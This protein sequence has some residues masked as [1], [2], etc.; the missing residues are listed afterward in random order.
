MPSPKIISLIPVILSLILLLFYRVPVWAQTRTG[1]ISGTIRG[2]DGKA[3]E[4]ATVLL[5]RQKDS[6]ISRTAVSDK[7]GGFIFHGVAT[8]TYFLSVTSI[9]FET[10]RSGPIAA[11]SGSSD[12]VLPDIVLS[13][14]ARNLQAVSVTDK[15]FVEWKL[16]KL[17]VHVAT[18]PFF[19]PGQ[20]TVDVLERSPGINID[21]MSNTISL[22][23]RAGTA[24]YIN[25][26]ISYLSGADLINYLRGLP[27]GSLDQIEIMSQPSAKYD[28]GGSGGAINIVLK[29]NQANGVFGSITTSVILGFYPKTRDNFLLNWRKDKFNLNFSYGFSDYKSFNDQHILSS[30][31]SDYGVAFSQYQDYRNSVI[32]TNLSHTPRLALDYQASKNTSLGL[33]LTGLFSSNKS[34]TNGPINLTD[35]LHSLI[36]KE[37]FS[38]LADNP[39]SN[40]GVNLNLQ[41]KLDGK[42]KELSVDA[43]YLHYHSPGSQSSY[44]YPYDQAGNP[45]APYLLN[46]DFP[47]GVNIYAFK[48][49][50]SQPFH[51]G[52]GKPATTGTGENKL[53]AGFKSS[54]VRTDN[55]AQYTLYDTLQKQWQP[56]TALSNHFIYSENINAAYVN[57]GKQ[58]NKKWSVE[59]GARAEQTL[60]R[61]NETTQG[62]RFTRKYFQVFPTL[63][64]GFSPNEVHSFTL[65]YGR[66]TDRPSY[67][68]L[69]PFRY[70]IN[71]YN[72]RQGNPNLQPE[73]VNNFE[74][75]YHYKSEFVV[76]LDYIK[77]DNLFSRIY[78]SSGTGNDL[79]TILTKE[80]VASRRNIFLFFFYNK[81]LTKWW[82]TN[83]T[84]ATVNSRIADP[85]DKGNPIDQVMVYRFD[86]NNKFSLPKGWGLELRGN[87]AGRRLEG[88]HIYALASGYLSL[89]V[90][91]KVLQGK[92]TLTANLNDALDLYR[93][94]QTS[95]GSGFFTQTDN[96]PESRYLTLT[97]NYRFGKAKQQQQRKSDGSAEDEQRRVNF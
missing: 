97:F 82:N 86:L 69:N 77:F 39:V 30:F 44:N 85:V 90:N 59:A 56:D 16:D 50:Y 66:R 47:A 23:G 48:S 41:Q 74:F 15:R 6:V 20:S 84:V 11:D 7:H 58:L 53:E 31:R 8:G 87:Y 13:P 29:K 34:N 12:R 46:G 93:P 83:W 24:V 68:D 5:H 92:G 38:S 65:S 1:P 70:Y 75:S 71:Q 27:A 88:V 19:D 55:D 52:R 32:S 9:G 73:S 60:S 64:V 63:Y 49:D 96:H 81:A 67:Q 51:F 42:G 91:K 18:S 26:R 28:A 17:V 21:Y 37:A 80:N 89:G 10:Y 54:Y 95:E 35:S 36:R 79:I 62:N 22:N 76:W 4:A 78:T 61:G 14:A 57:I 94:G 33:N 40:P 43:D 2:R 3:L 25:G 45:L 72:I